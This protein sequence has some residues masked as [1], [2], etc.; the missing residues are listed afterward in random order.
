MAIICRDHRL[1]F[2]QAPRTGCTAIENLLQERFGGESLPS[3]DIMGDDG[4]VRVGRKHCTIRQLLAE[5]LIPSDYSQR[6]TTVTSVRNPF[7]SLVSLYVKRREKYHGERFLKNPDSW[8]HTARGLA[9]D[10]DFCRTHSFDEWLTKRY[11]V[12][13]LDQL[14]GRGR[15][16][17]SEKYTN[18]VSIVMRFERLQDDFAAMMRGLGVSG[19]V[20]IPTINTTQERRAAYQDYY[21]PAGRALVEY[22]FHHELRRYGYSFDGVT[23]AAPVA[24]TSVAN[25]RS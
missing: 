14:L 24:G 4:F 18:G 13:R 19:D 23:E 22:V 15:R 17:L 21:T 20:T 1:L 12:T 6:M 3:A 10:M 16:A 11:A 8:V 9:E 2:I 7:D 5:G 25:A